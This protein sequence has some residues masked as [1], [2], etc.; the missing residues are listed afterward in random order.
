MSS[1]SY[2]QYSTYAQCPKKWKLDYLDG[3]RTY[4][5]SIHTI[6]GS[7][8]H[9]TIQ[10]Y[11]KTVLERSAKTADRLDL[12]GMLKE[13]LINM[14]KESLTKNGNIHYTT[15]QELNDFY[16]SGTQILDY[17]RKKRVQFV[18]SRNHELIGIEVPLSINLDAGVKFVGF[19]DLVLKD[20]KYDTYT[21]YDIKTSTMGW[22]KNQKKDASKTAQLILYKKF[23]AEQFGVDVEK[24]DV[25]Y[26]ILRRKINEQAEFVAKRIQSF[27]PASGKPTR[28][29]IIES[30][31]SFV[32]NC[33]TVE[34]K[35][36]KEGYYPAVK[37]T[38]CT[39]CNYNKRHDLCP[40]EHR[41]LKVK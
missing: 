34:G 18:N 25:E 30:F 26:I 12:H 17:F 33:F 40:T 24:I 16:L 41:T 2:S 1:V 37:S 23:Y 9:F 20:K 4:E 28:K 38:A 11:V 3:L 22:N 15:P 8:M 36:N 35:H 32:K 5:Q 31:D 19:I 6:F 13:T 10:E 27:K 29:K 14:Y 39:Y 7:A 21:I